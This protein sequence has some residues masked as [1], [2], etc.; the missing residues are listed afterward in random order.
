MTKRSYTQ[1]VP[2]I[3]CPHCKSRSIVRDS[4]QVDD[5]TRDLRYM[6]DNDDCGHTFVA[7]L[8]IIRTVRPSAKPN[9]SVILPIGEWRSRPAN[10]DQRIPVNDN[11]TPAAELAP[12]P[13]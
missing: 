12:T 7:M 9:P 2:G 6:C 4:V 10:D 11:E 5:L 13:G 1:R 8:A 3:V